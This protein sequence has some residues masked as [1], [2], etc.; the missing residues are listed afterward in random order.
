MPFLPAFW[1]SMRRRIATFD[2]RAAKIGPPLVQPKSDL[3][4]ENRCSIHHFHPTVLSCRRGA[5][6]EFTDGIEVA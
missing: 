3:L 6:G 4:I 1:A 5:A 2:K